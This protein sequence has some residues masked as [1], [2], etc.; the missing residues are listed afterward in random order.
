M[1]WPYGAHI[2]RRQPWIFCLGFKEYDREGYDHKFRRKK[3]FNPETLKIQKQ[4]VYHEIMFANW[5]WKRRRSRR[6][7]NS[8]LDDPL[9]LI[10]T[11]FFIILDIYWLTE[12]CESFLDHP[13]RYRFLPTSYLGRKPRLDLTFTEDETEREIGVLILVL[14]SESSSL[15][16]L[17]PDHP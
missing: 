11:P 9:V 6:R 2:F 8:L 16:L 5:R 10:M 12:F 13:V 17:F 3:L 14:E 7:R 1:C 15:S 4:W